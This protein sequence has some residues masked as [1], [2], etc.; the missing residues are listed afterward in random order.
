M[1]GE[2]SV[3]SACP[4]CGAAVPSGQPICNKC[5]RPISPRS[6]ES[7]ASADGSAQGRSAPK[8]LSS[9]PGLATP[10]P[11]PPTTRGPLPAEHK[12]GPGWSKTPDGSWTPHLFTFSN[13]RGAQLV[14]YVFKTLAVIVLIGGT[15]SALEAI[16]TVHQHNVSGTDEGLIV[17]GIVAGSIIAASAMAFFGYLLQLLVRDPL[18]H[19]LQ[20]SRRTDIEGD[21]AL[22]YARIF[23]NVRRFEYGRSESIARTNRRQAKM[24]HESFGIHARALVDQLQ[25][26]MH[27]VER[28]P[29]IRDA[30][31]RQYGLSKL[32]WWFVDSM[33]DWD[34]IV[35]VIGSSAVPDSMDT[36][37]AYGLAWQGDADFLLIA[38]SE[39][40]GPESTTV[41]RLTC[42]ETPVRVFGYDPR[43]L[44]LRPVPIR[45]FD[46]AIAAVRMDPSDHRRDSAASEDPRY[47]IVDPLIRWANDQ[48]PRLQDR[49]RPSYRSWQYRGSPLLT[50]RPTRKG[51]RVI[52][53]SRKI[54][55][56]LGQ[57]E[58]YEI[59]TQSDEA[60][61]F[62]AI[63]KDIEAAIEAIQGG[64]GRPDAEHRLQSHLVP[65]PQQPSPLSR[66]LGLRYAFREF[67]SVAWRGG[68]SHG[69]ARSH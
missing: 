17:A 18:R 64:Q 27:H 65:D 12:P 8:H 23:V 41:L 52:A 61:A 47:S 34:R 63:K 49:S 26:R 2:T 39:L 40:V 20:P 21:T 45:T 36:V 54:V 55:G 60:V 10:E 67:P 48:R 11:T 4:N 14:A 66:A 50:V 37:L 28:L 30:R 33:K 38:P 25:P 9:T 1:Q 42:I 15:I 43:S 22:G 53:G 31:E 59:T 57:P 6:A 69:K 44:E 16:T 3:G 7:G 32:A 35:A 56:S 62:E 51:I 29:G 58:S 13:F 24:E 5:A 46:E 19:P 68:P